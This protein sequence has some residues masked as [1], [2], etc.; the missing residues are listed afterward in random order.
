MELGTIIAVPAVVFGIAGR[1]LD[2]LFGTQHLLFFIA[3]ALAF[4]SSFVTIWKKV[5]EI[6]ARMPKI[7]P[8]KKKP[9]VDP[10]IAREQEIIH[11]LFRPPSE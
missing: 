8:K 10:E 6:M 4:L 2:T 11:D 3:L 7:Q 5:R 9:P 1:Y